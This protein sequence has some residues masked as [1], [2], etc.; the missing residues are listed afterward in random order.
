MKR[1][2]LALYFIGC[3]SSSAASSTL[4]GIPKFHTAAAARA[5]GDRQEKLGKFE[6]AAGSPPEYGPPAGVPVVGNLHP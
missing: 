1:V 3:I 2:F 6:D 5:W 4:T